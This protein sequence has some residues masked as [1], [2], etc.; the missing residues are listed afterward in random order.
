MSP[1]PHMGMV[2]YTTI[3]TVNGCSLLLIRLLLVGHSGHRCSCS[4]KYN[5]TSCWRVLLATS[6]AAPCWALWSLVWP[7]HKLGCAH[8]TTSV[9][10][11]TK[12][13]VAKDMALHVQYL[14][15]SILC[16]S[17]EQIQQLMTSGSS[18]PFPFILE[19]LPRV[20]SWLSNHQGGHQG[21]WT[22]D[23]QWDTR[24]E[25]HP[26]S[27]SRATRTW[28]LAG[29]MPVSP[30]QFQDQAF[31]IID[32]VVRGLKYGIELGLSVGFDGI[33][34]GIRYTVHH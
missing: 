23:D 10:A 12:G 31:Q 11:A 18:N 27:L 2:I 9:G 13:W 34:N 1:C 32:I 30:K 3:M 20:S 7:L 16:N 33:S 25:D 21:H 28:S 14:F 22:L 29:R 17:H 8:A 5:C 19:P 6:R 24:C 26:G 15:K 4:V